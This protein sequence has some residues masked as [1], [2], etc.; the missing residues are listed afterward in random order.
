MATDLQ[1]RGAATKDKILDAAEQ[2][3]TE[4]GVGATSLRSIVAEANVNVA[5]VHYHF[6]SKEDL[7]RAVIQRRLSELSSLRAAELNTLIERWGK[8][9]IPINEL[10]TA[11]MSPALSFGKD[12]TR[13]GPN[14]ARFVA[15]M[16]SES[17]PMVQEELFNQIHKIVE[18]YIQELQKSMPKCPPQELSMRMAFAAGAMI[19]A[20]LLPLRPSFVEYFSFNNLDSNELLEILVNFCTRGMDENTGVK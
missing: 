1:T 20:I 13:G 4:H 11:F 7:I 15:R 8:K 19:Q 14:F 9:P 6:G 18:L 17:D 2:L 16:H 10:L 5:S 12:Q 3:F